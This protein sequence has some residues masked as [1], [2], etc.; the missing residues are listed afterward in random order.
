MSYVTFSPSVVRHM[1]SSLGVSPK[2]Y[3]GQNFLVSN[4]IAERIA[5]EGDLTQKDTVLEV[6]PGLGI[7]TQELARKAGRVLAIEREEKF[8]SYLAKRFQDS[9]VEVVKGDIL[10]SLY[11]LSRFNISC[12]KIISNLPY[13]ITARFLRIFLSEVFPKPD[14]TVVMIQKEV[15]G[16]LI[17]KAG[18]MTKL[19]VLAQIYGN[20]KL[21]F[22]V[23]PVHFF[24]QPAVF[25]TVVSIPI[26]K[27][28]SR[29]FPQHE[30]IFW[31][32]VRI[33]FSAKRKMLYRNLSNGLHLPVD[34]MKKLLK[35]AYI[36][37]NARAQELSID[38]WVT[39]VDKYVK[40]Y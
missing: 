38:S 28:P 7:L 27:T 13:G 31:R 32:I 20:P 17:S 21:C 4:S 24:P 10:S 5:G 15:A 6:G 37:E 18:D 33:G 40:I 19:S 8:A 22:N 35:T 30:D 12:Y 9:N 36:K 34:E 29:I 1:L 11:L 23:S 14:H 16:K 3:L 39:L 26:K 25:S 2:E